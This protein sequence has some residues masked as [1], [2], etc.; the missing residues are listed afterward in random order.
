MLFPYLPC[1]GF[2][3]DIVY[4][5]QLRFTSFRSLSTGNTNYNK[6]TN[7]VI[8]K[9]RKS[10]IADRQSSRQIANP[11]FSTAIRQSQIINRK[12]S[13]ENRKSSTADP[14][15]HIINRKSSTATLNLKLSIVNPQLLILNPMSSTVNYQS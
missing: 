11:I 12:S 14:Q 6:P 3:G 1:S 8:I 15:S 9:N 2:S 7:K 5:S 10:S 4:T 13:I